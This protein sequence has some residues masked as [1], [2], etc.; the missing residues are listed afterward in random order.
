[1]NQLTAEETRVI[2]HKGTERPFSGEYDEFFADGTYI[3]RRCEAPLYVSDSKF[4]SGCGWPAFDQEIEGAVRR[5]PDTDGQRVE[6]ECANCGGHLGHVFVGERLTAKN[7][8]HCVNS[9]SLKFIP[10]AESSPQPSGDK[11]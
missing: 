5:L 10:K 7:T 6:I 8:R 2:V 3:C 1:M 4:N 11:R 9:I